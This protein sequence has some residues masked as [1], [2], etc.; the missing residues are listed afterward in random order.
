MSCVSFSLRVYTLHTAL[1]CDIDTNDQNI[2][3]IINCRIYIN[4]PV[5]YK[6]YNT[7]YYRSIVRNTFVH[8]YLKVIIDIIL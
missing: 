2:E 5:E 1:S 8:F 3:D 4:P 7:Y 6:C